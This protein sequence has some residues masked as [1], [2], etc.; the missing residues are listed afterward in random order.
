M[1]RPPRS[2]RPERSRARRL[3]YALATPPVRPR[4]RG[5]ADEPLRVVAVARVA[6]I[7]GD[8]PRIPRPTHANA[9][10]YDAIQ[11]R[12][13]AIAP[14]LLPVRFGSLVDDEELAFILASRAA[15]L[16]TALAHVRNRVQMTVR[17]V[18]ME[19]GVPREGGR[20]NTLQS[21]TDYLRQ[22]AAVTRVAELDPLRDAV[23]RWLRDERVETH[24]RIVTLHHL[25]PRT[26]VDAYR[27]AIERAAGE[28][29]RQVVISG[30]HPAYAF[31]E[32]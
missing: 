3:V 10:R 15:S 9:V 11:R 22:R 26:A 20:Q 19:P 30:P 5:L 14:S 7:V 12:L 6:A 1:A 32:I 13:V 4:V 28:Q 21:G 18:G 24:E 25:V 16:T 23:R 29:Q 2:P 17:V 27:R 31:A 8:V